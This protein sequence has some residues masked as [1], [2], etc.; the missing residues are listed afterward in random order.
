[1]S[2]EAQLAVAEELTEHGLLPLAADVWMYMLSA[3]EQ[4]PEYALMAIARLVAFGCGEEMIPRVPAEGGHAAYPVADVARA[5]ASWLG[6]LNRPE[7]GGGD[8]DL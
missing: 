7:F 3:Q 6:S 1:L 2:A 8:S 5:V 4:A